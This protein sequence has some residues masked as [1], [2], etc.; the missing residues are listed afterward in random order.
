MNNGELL[1]IIQSHRANSLGADSGELSIERA[2]AMDRYHG[3]LYGDEVEGRSQITS[4]DISE[5]V[6]WAMPGI[7][8]VFLQAGVL[9][10]FRPIGP[11]DEQLAQQESDYVNL[12]MMQDNPGFMVL[13]DA[14]KDTLLLKNG[15][16]KRIWEVSK[17]T[18]EEQYTGYTVDRLTVMIRDME[19][20][21]ATV[22]IIGQESHFITIPGMPDQMNAAQGI[23]TPPQIEVFDVKLKITREEGKLLWMAVPS[24][25][26]RVSKKCRGSLQESPFTEHVTRK[27]RSELIEMGM[28]RTF[29]DSLPSHTERD[30]STQQFARDSVSEESDDDGAD[31]ADRSMNEIEYCEAYVKVDWDGDGVAEL[32]KVVTVSNQIPPGDDWN[33][34]IPAVALTG[35]VAKRVP[36]RHIGESLYDELADLQQIMTVL[37]RQLLDNIYR[38]NNGETVINENANVRD[39]MTSTPG[40]IKR[41]K[42]TD[43]VQNSVMPLPTQP[44][45]DK[46]LPVIS[47]MEEAKETRTGISKATTGLDPDVLQNATKG[48]FM[49]NLNRASQKMEMIARMLAETGVKED[50]VQVHALLIRHQDVSRQVQL[51]GRWTPVNPQEWRE[52]N[53]L[54]VKVGL[55][56]GTEDDRRNKLQMLLGM[57]GPLLAAVASAPKEVYAKMY[58]LFEDAAKTLGAE[59]PEK[60]AIAPGSQEHQQILLDAQAAAEAARQQGGAG[61]MTGAAQVK[62]QADMQIQSERTQAQNAIANAKLN[63]DMQVKASEDS[64]RREKAMLEAQMEAQDREAERRHQMLMEQMKQ[65]RIDGREAMKAEVQLMLKSIFADMG[66]PGISAGV[67]GSEGT[68]TVVMADVQPDAPA[69]GGAMGM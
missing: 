6:D 35:Y 52:R 13:H 55:G 3:R 21:G 65:D 29:V 67:Q 31:F 50:V 16:T 24:E 8:R 41:T 23:M 42:G 44:I 59:M 57:Q 14:I 26:V 17:K 45:I 19:A 54:T 33:E 37:K 51:R 9:A 2:L 11:E 68:D 5:A 47:Y 1:S 63:A 40:G 12:V 27:T 36:H 7:M 62:A 48:A 4:R 60:Y 22:E 18:R 38:I 32:R 64:F 66:R 58:A 10:E 25:E 20:D 28:D 43:P 49:E 39:F 30:N 15:Y 34:Q 56:T 46:L 61:D 69:D 53:D